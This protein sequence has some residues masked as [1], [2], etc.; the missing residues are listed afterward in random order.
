MKEQ[1]PSMTTTKCAHRK[2]LTGYKVAKLTTR[3]GTKKPSATSRL[4]M[5]SESNDE[6]LKDG[7]GS[8]IRLF[9]YV[10]VTPCT[11]R[12]LCWY[13][14]LKHELMPPRRADVQTLD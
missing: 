4:T 3:S 13:Q 10:P 6:T 9:S 2:S 12:G 8:D 14:L 11:V 1:T 5:V 7:V